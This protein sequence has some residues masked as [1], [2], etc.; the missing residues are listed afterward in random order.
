MT[1][2][3]DQD[4][5]TI[6]RKSDY[7]VQGEGEPAFVMHIGEFCPPLRNLLH[8]AGVSSSCFISAYNPRSEPRTDEENARAQAQLIEDV[9]LMG[10][11]YLEGVGEDPDGA[12]AGEPCLLVLGISHEDTAMLGNRYG[13]NAVLW[14]ESEGMPQLLLLR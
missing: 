8:R 11:S 4:L 6:Y 9:R 3:I 1:S 7:R 14:C 12:C 2:A 5:L 13:Q 10:L